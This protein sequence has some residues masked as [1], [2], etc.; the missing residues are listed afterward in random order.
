MRRSGWES[1][2]MVKWERNTRDEVVMELR[3]NH[4]ATEVD[5][6]EFVRMALMSTAHSAQT[7]FQF[8]RALRTLIKARMMS[9]SSSSDRD[10]GMASKLVRS[11]R[12]S[13]FGH[14]PFSYAA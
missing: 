5:R 8:A 4:M 9:F 12:L 13:A 7:G 3:P 6:R 10:E 14:V 2:C 11:N 1:T